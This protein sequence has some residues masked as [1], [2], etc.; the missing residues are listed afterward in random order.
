MK[1]SGVVRKYMG[2]CP[3]AH[4]RVQ[5]P[6]TRPDTEEVVPVAGGSLPYRITRWLGLFRNQALLQVIG[7]LCIGL[8]MLAGFGSLSNLDL[9]IIGMLAGLPYSAITGIWYFRIFNEV[10][11]DGPL[12]LWNRFDRTSA[13]LTVV[14]LVVSFSAWTLV[15][16]GAIPGVDIAMTTAFF[17]G[18][19][20]VLFWGMLVAIQ[21]WESGTRRLL[22]YNGTILRLERDDTD[23][24]R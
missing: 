4:T 17:A 5:K 8:F 9:F 20:A 7:T 3:R 12:E 14:G 19:V 11:N 10:L 22:Y 15:L 21:R 16:L 6:E 24:P 1:A 23:A 2:W 13:T 18:V